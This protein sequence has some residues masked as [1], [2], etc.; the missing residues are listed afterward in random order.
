MS[1][2]G[3]CKHE[4]YRV[5]IQGRGTSPALAPESSASF[6]SCGRRHSANSRNP[7]AYEAWSW[8]FVLALLLFTGERFIFTVRLFFLSEP[9]DNRA[10]ELHG[11]HGSAS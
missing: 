5:F 1:V 10:R 11:L 9:E 7:G 6:Q 4:M 8:A 3:G 2:V